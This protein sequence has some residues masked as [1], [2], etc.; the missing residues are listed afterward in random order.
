MK[1]V[2]LIAGLLPLTLGAQT[3]IFEENFDAYTA[4]NYAGNESPY[5]TSWSETPGGFDDCF[6]SNAQASSPSN[7]IEI[8]GQS[9]PMDAL[10]Q[11]PQSYDAVGHYRF[12]MKMYIPTGYAGYFNC[13]ES[14]TPGLG[15]KCDVFFSI[16]GTGYL[17]SNGDT[18]SIEFTYPKD[19]WFDVV[20]EADLT[21]DQGE[22]FISG[23]SEGTFMWSPGVTGTETFKRWGGVNYYAYGPNNEQS[24]YFVDDLKL[25]DITD[26]TS[27]SSNSNFDFSVYPNPSNGQIAIQWEDNSTY[28]LIVTDIT[29][30]LVYSENN[31]TANS[32]FNLTAE[33]GTYFVQLS[34]NES[35]SIKKII[36]E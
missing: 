21:N 24:N 23:T 18:S 34:N 19:A 5:M 1:K 33:K 26:Y 16:A 30:K 3:T 31:I 32:N 10:C 36:I 17:S 8:V 12:S 20:V 4:G 11:F 22:L 29:G 2:L 14:T 28:D 6:I 15:W 35:S 7:S 27:V 25:E 9:G 13:Q